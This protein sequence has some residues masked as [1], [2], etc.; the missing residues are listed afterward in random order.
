MLQNRN[1]DPKLPLKG[2]FHKLSVTFTD[3]ENRTIASTSV[4]NGAFEIDHV[5]DGRF[6][7]TIMLVGYV[8]YESGELEFAAGHTVDLGEVRLSMEENG[9]ERV[10]VQGERSKIVYRLDR[11]AVN[12]SAGAFRVFWPA[13]MACA[14]GAVDAQV[15]VASDGEAI[16]TLPFV[17]RVTQV[18]TGAGE[19]GGD[20]YSLFLEAIEKFEGADALI[21]DAVA[22]AQQAASVAAEALED[23]QGASGAITAANAAATAATQAKEDLLA[24]AARGDFDGAPGAP[25]APGK[26]G[27]DGADGVSPTAKVEQT[28]AGA[29]VTVTDAT[30]TTTATLTHGPKGD[31]GDD[32]EKGDKGDPFTY[33]DFTAEQL[34]ALKGQKGDPGEDGSDGVDGQD[35]APGADGQDG[36]DGVSCTHS[37]AGTVLTVTSASGTSSADLKGEQGEKG[38]PVHPVWT[39]EKVIDWSGAV[40]DAYLQLPATDF[41]S[42]QAGWTLRFNYANL[43]IGAQGHIST[44]S[45]GDMPDGTEYISLTASYFEYDITAAMLAELQ[46]NGCVV[47]GI[48]FTLTGVELIDPTQV[49]SMTCTLVADAVK[50][51]EAGEQPQITVNLQS[52][53]AKDMTTTVSLKLRRDNYTDYYAKSEQVTVPAGETKQVTFPLTLE[54]GF[55]HA[56]V[57]ANYN[58]LRDFNIGYNPTAIACTPDMQD[59]FEA[60]WNTAKAELAAIPMNAKMTLDEEKSTGARNVYFVEMQSIGNGDDQPVTIR[61]YYAVPKAEGTYPVVIT[62]N[63][64]DS[65][66]ASQIYWPD[67]NGNPDWIEFNVSNR[68]QLV[69]NRPPYK[70]ENAFYGDW[71]A[72]NFGNKDTYYYRGAYMDVVRSIDFVCSQ[73]NV[74]QENI[75]MTGGSQGGAFTIAGA[76]L[77]G[78]LNAIAPSIQFMG[79]F[80]VYF[81]VGAWPASVARQKQQELGL[82][83]EQMYTF[84]SYFDTK[85]LAT[86][87]TC[88]VLTA[89]GL[90]DPVCPPRTNF[91][92]YVNFQSAEKSYTVNPE[93]QHETP[94]E[95]Y[96]Q[97]MDFFTSHLKSSFPATVIEAVQAD[98]PADGPAYNIMGQRV[99]KDYKGIVIQNGRKYF[100]R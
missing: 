74:Q 51:W 64:Y 41:A 44:G 19:G 20:G 33:A 39:G 23:A 79:D 96:N 77:D 89:M 94:A 100:Q 6:F 71:F 40:P 35:G 49:P 43:A 24:A 8:P 3:A 81:Q 82:T 69:N 56:V 28:E 68:G 31:K 93:C 62:Q 75:F 66:G 90:Q 97:Y 57:E 38:D 29:L 7:V 85:N 32:G 50:C 78:R 42:A 37:W 73:P 65:S 46:K 30:G 58:L 11:Q 60:F 88:P 1:P 70:D 86:L 87:V 45:W 63:G 52:L 80:P 16:S 26:D 98:I 25:G 83:D 53:E 99:G 13:A 17:V 54:P 48:G 10:V 55:Y 67:T 18:L 9:L 12:A 22:K 92:P 59:D 14:E 84:L 15:M 95:W 72:Y 27:T 47:S 61:G 2:L 5:R 34:A 4:R 36:Q 21:S 76:A 91:A